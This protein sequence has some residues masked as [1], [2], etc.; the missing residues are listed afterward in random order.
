MARKHDD[1]EWTLEQLRKAIRRKI[2]VL[3][4]GKS[5]QSQQY[6]QPHQQY[7]HH[8]YANTMFEG[9]TD[10]NRSPFYAFCA[11]ENFSNQCA[12]FKS[13]KDRLKVAMQKRLCN[14]CL[15]SGHFKNDCRSKKI[16]CCICKGPHHSSLHDNNATNQGASFTTQTTPPAAAPTTSPTTASSAPLATTISVN[17]P[18][19]IDSKG[20]VMNASVTSSPFVFLKTAIGFSKSSNSGA[21]DSQSFG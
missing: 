9:V 14:N 18:Q 1:D 20:V 3:E 6:R 13:A 15:R 12:K 8:Q 21:D 17:I 5:T 7:H 4:A 19:L 16:R 2:R 10:G 11:G